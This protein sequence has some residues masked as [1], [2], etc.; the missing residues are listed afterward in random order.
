MCGASDLSA[1][2]EFYPSRME[3]LPVTLKQFETHWGRRMGIIVCSPKLY[4]SKK[5]NR[6]TYVTPWTLNPTICGQ[7]ARAQNPTLSAWTLN[8]DPQPR[9]ATA[10]RCMAVWA[11]HRRK[12]P[13][14]P[15]DYLPL[16]GKGIWWVLRVARMCEQSARISAFQGRQ[17]G[18][19]PPQF[20]P[21]E[22]SPPP[23]N[24]RNCWGK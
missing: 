3:P 4:I 17:G 15:G 11:D 5:P 2:G 9:T 7:H 14:N 1:N 10:A 16:I 6:Y 22:G 19:P 23:P 20:A 18:P 21:M 13:W 8:P 24:R 12:N